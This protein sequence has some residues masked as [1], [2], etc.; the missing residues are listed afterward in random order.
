VTNFSGVDPEL[1]NYNGIYDG[2]SITIPRTFVLGFK[3][4]L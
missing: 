1:I 4:D 3:L 2:A